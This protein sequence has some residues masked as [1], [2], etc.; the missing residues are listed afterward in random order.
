MVCIQN[1]LQMQKLAAEAA[2]AN[3]Q[4]LVLEGQA[5]LDELVSGPLATETRERYT[6]M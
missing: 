4:M 3:G 1:V 2:M 5:R 6:S